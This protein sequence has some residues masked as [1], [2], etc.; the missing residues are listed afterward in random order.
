[1]DI[2]IQAGEATYQNGDFGK[3]PTLCTGLA[4]GGELLIELYKATKDMLWLDRAK[5]FVK[6]A[7]AYRVETEEGDR[8]PTNT[9]GLYSQDFVYG[10]SG[11]G[12]F[13]LRVHQP[14]LLAPPLM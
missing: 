3:N 7:M 11:T 5:T 4:G 9:P 10:A 12:Y 1:M 8:W 2:A 6:T 13:F 14:E